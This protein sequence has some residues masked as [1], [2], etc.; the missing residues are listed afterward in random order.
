MITE[1]LYFAD[2]YLSQFSAHILARAERGGKPAVALDQSAFYPEGGGQPADSG[3]LNDVPVLDVQAEQGLVWHVLAR[4]LDDDFVQGTV[5]WP[6]RFDHMQQHHGQHLLSAAFERLYGLRTVS[7]H[8]GAAAATIDLDTTGLMAEQ[9]AAAEEL[10]NQVIW[11]DRPVLA[12]FVG[13]EDLAALPLRKPPTVDGPIRVVSVPDFDHSA[14]GGTHP[15]ATGGVGLLHIRR[16]ERRGE[17]QRVEFLCGGRALRDLR[18]KN[19]ALGRLAS[20]LSVGAE[21]VEAAAARM[22]EAEERNR[23]RLEDAGERLLGYEAAELLAQAESARG[24]RVVR[25][26]FADRPLDEVRALAKLIA[27]GGG[28]ALLGLRAEKTQL[29]FAR[30]DGLNVDCGALLRE[31]LAPHGGRGGGQPALAQGGLPDPAWLEAALS[32]AFVSLSA[33]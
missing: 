14:C 19:V 30:A 26:A 1:R 13:A 11:E 20:M 9:A 17:T 12:R 29:I 8:L 2:S 31:A 28:V 24:L 32:A 4:P 33:S 5:D 3:A 27:G 18:W 6:R 16:W 21:E 10:T 7:F 23:K 25:H 22:R 15:R